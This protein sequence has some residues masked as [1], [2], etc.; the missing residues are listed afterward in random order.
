MP[1][2]IHSVLDLKPEDPGAAPAS[3]PE[4]ASPAA[5]SV[6]WSLITFILGVV[7]WLGVVV[8]APFAIYAGGD[9]FKSND[10]LLAVGLL[11]GL[12]GAVCVLVS[13]VCG[14]CAVKHRRVVLWWVIPSV[15]VVGFL[16]FVVV[17]IIM[18]LS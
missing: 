10:T 11:L 14:L 13:I 12:A 7:A 17:S 6:R 15:L 4:F 3:T 1:D 9:L 8:I 2:D 16:G 18:S 5:G